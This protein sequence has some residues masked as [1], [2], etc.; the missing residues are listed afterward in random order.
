VKLFETYA[1][2]AIARRQLEFRRDWDTRNRAEDEMLALHAERERWQ[3]LTASANHQ[4][5]YLRPGQV[6]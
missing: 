1:Q 4:G 6:L 2:V 3:E 5:T